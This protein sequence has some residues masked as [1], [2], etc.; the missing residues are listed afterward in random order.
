MILGCDIGTG[1][2]KAVLMEDHA[3]SYYTIKPTNANPDRAMDGIIK[4]IAEKHGVGLSD[5]DKVFITGWGD[6][7][8]S[9]D[10]KSA[11]LLN[12][13]GKAAIWAFPSCRSVLHLG[14]QH[15]LIVSLNE[16]GRVMEFRENDKCASGS[17]RF[18]EIISQALEIDVEDI[19]DMIMRADKQINISS[20]CA[21]FAESEVISLVNKGES[22][23]NIISAMVRSL[24]KNV[25]TLSRRI[26][27]KKDCLLSGGLANNC[28]IKGYIQ[29][30]LNLELQVFQPVPDIIAAVGAALYA[31]GNKS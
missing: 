12:C 16:K 13:L 19:A 24:C 23:K 9:M 6:E 28:A 4:D 1:Y 14:T 21:V 18:L 8:V 22:V 29:D 3:L 11:G 27:I 26:N 17:G 30:S 31:G 7:R 20:Q 2:S 25:A 5:I 15:S 10:H